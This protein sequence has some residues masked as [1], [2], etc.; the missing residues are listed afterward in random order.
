MNQHDIANAEGGSSICAD[1]EQRSRDS[2]RDGG[3]ECATINH[4]TRASTSDHRLA[5]GF[6]VRALGWV[7]LVKVAKSAL[8]AS[9]SFGIRANVRSI[10]TPGA[11]VP[12]SATVLPSF[13]VNGALDRLIAVVCESDVKIDAGNAD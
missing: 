12:V 10:V 7:P 1:T 3:R 13:K 6:N 2:R 8:Q 5:T 11:N 4:D 9:A